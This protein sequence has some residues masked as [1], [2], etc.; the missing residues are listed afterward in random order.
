M[1]C[2]KLLLLAGFVALATLPQCGVLKTARSVCRKVSPVALLAV[3]HVFPFFTGK[4]SKLDS[5]EGA[6]PEREGM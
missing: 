2:I 5:V 6:S 4:R 3:P 1:L